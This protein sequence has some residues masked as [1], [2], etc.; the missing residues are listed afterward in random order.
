MSSGSERP[1]PYIFEVE[2]EGWI[3]GEIQRG[4]WMWKYPPNFISPMGGE[5]LWERGARRGCARKRTRT[6]HSKK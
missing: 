1:K 2:T 6:K 5:K 4:V 3:D